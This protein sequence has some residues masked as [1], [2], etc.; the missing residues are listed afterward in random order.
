ML[1]NVLQITA[2]HTKNDLGQNVNSAKTEKPRCHLSNLV[3]VRGGH[4]ENVTFRLRNQQ[5]VITRGRVGMGEM[6][7]PF[8]AD[9]IS[10]LMA[11][12]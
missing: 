9:G 3:S 4:L 5:A 1:L 12:R 10:S 11:L 7:D 2:P 6:G 8:L